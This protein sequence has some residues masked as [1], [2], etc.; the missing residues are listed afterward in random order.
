MMFPVDAFRKT[1]EK[2]VAIMTHHHI[3]FHLTGGITSAAY[4]E[5]RMTQD[6][7][8]VAD[9]RG[10]AEHSDEVIAAF[11]SV[12]FLFDPAAVRAA[13][14]DGEMFQ[15][16]DLRES[17]K[18]DVYAR[19]LIPGELNRSATLAIFEGLELPIVS[20]A[21]AA[22]SKLIWVSKGSH[23]SRRDLRHLF[24]T[25]DLVTQLSIR[26]L[27]EAAR[28]SSLLDEVLVEPDEIR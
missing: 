21:D 15:L 2:F 3:R 25:S 19:E 27:A 26:G 4:G 5:P 23:K 1:M 18:I 16:F 14:R 12:D 24:R 13:I 20:R 11:Q 6:I 10:L 8:F 9:P 17:L 28:L 7:D 22:M